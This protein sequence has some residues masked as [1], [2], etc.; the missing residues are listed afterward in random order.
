MRFF[1]FFERGGYGM[2]L[3]LIKNVSKWGQKSKKEG[4][5]LWCD[6][7]KID[8]SKKTGGLTVQP[9]Q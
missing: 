7:I 4:G 3:I 5:G 2:T 6:T 8:D 9:L 1:G